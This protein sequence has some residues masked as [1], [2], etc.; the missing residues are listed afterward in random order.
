MTKGIPTL[1]TTVA[2]INCAASV[3]LFELLTGFVLN[4]LSFID[5][6]IVVPI[7][8]VGGLVYGISWASII[9]YVPEKF[10]P[11]AGPLRILLLLVG[12]YTS[13]YASERMGYQGAGPVAALTIGMVCAKT[14]AMQGW[15]IKENAPLTFFHTIWIVIEPVLFGV[16]G[17]V[18][19]NDIEINTVVTATAILGF[20]LVVKFV[21]TTSVFALGCN[22]SCRTKTFL[23]LCWTVKAT[24]QVCQIY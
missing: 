22:L 21:A 9:T 5:Q 13:I 10:D 8:I 2:G 16:T 11:L 15:D 7:S 23:A 12:G 6:C 24:I 4:E 3:L 1:I 18:N 14:W 20:S 17:A 19:L